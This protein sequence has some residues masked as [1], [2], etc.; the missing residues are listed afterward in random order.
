MA[1]NRRLTSFHFPYLPLHL[2]VGRRSTDVEALLDTG[3]DGDVAVPPEVLSGQSPNEYVI[4]TL[5]DGSPVLA[6]AFVATAQLGDLDPFPVLVTALGDEPLI[7]RGVS[8]RFKV[9]LDH[10]HQVVVEP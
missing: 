6:P 5:A 7:G 8:D 1:V 3:F 9:T 10:G 2:L 4:W